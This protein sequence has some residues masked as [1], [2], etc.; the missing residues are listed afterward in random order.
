MTVSVLL[1][2]DNAANLT[3]KKA[4]LGTFDNCGTVIGVRDPDTAVHMLRSLP[5]FDLVVADID[6]SET[7]KGNSSHNK[8]G[9]AVARWLKDSRYPA[10]VAGYSSYFADDEISEGDKETFDDMVDRS[11]DGIA[12]DEKLETWIK[13][14][15]ENDSGSTLRQLLFEAYASD[16]AHK[17]RGSTAASIA[18]VVSL[19]TL[20]DYESDEL[21]EIRTSGFSLSLLLPDVDDEIRKAI[22][23]WIKRDSD[24]V[25]IEVVG[26]PY[27]YATGE[28][29]ASAKEALKA[30]ILGYYQDLKGQHSKAE[31]GAYVKILFQFLDSLF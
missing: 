9:I 29:E 13:K 31:L 15:S 10:Y 21:E 7:A 22:P 2:E 3:A 14:A 11:V 17:T 19:D 20:I 8:A 1:I 5:R 6:L 27:L 16:S 4:L 23:I 26:Q 30:L 28:T 12:L 18:P 24:S 25:A